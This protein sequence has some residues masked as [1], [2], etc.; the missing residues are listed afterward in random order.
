MGHLKM[1]LL[2]AQKERQSALMNFGTFSSL[3]VSIIVVVLPVPGGCERE[4]ARVSTNRL[5]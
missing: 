1:H 5:I 2:K 4:V 3:T